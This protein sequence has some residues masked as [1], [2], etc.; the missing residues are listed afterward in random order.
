VVHVLTVLFRVM[1]ILLAKTSS[2]LPHDLIALLSIE[3]VCF[4]AVSFLIG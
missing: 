2:E 4:I 1:S 3:T